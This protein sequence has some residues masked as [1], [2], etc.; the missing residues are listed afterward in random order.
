MNKL[1]G[2]LLGIAILLC[3]GIASAEIEVPPEGNRITDLSGL[4]NAAQIQSLDAK[5]ERLETFNGVNIEILLVP[6]L[7]REPIEHYAARVDSVWHP[8]ENAVDKH[9]LFL[10]SAREKTAHLTIGEGLQGSLSQAAA[11]TILKTNVLPDLRAGLT[12]QGLSAG[13]DAIIQQVGEAQI[14]DIT[15]PM[16]TVMIKPFSLEEIGYY[17]MII[18]GIIALVAI[19][20]YAGKRKDLAEY[21]KNRRKRNPFR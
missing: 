6:A 16:H 4:L 12:S 18:L 3:T 11:E 13:I 9:I 1:I 15:P 2:P 21:L 7:D 19:L 5:L 10:V 8:E 20:V 17:L 14:D